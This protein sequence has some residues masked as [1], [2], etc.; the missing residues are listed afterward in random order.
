[1]MRCRFISLAVALLLGCSVAMADGL[2]SLERFIKGARSGRADF[3]QVVSAPS[4]AGE[5]GKTRTSSGSFAFSRPDRFRFDYRKPFAQTIVADGVT[6]WMYDADLNQV[7]SRKQADVLGST[8]AALIASASDLAVLRKDY[9]LKGEPDKDG[10]QW[11]L[12]TPKTKDGQ[13]QSVRVGFRAGDGVP[14]LVVLDILDSFGQRS[15][16]RFAQ[17]EANPALPA[18]LF[19]FKPPAGADVIRQ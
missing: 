16:L 12:A 18:D 1:M 4:R 8:P 19:Q 15:E 9:V 6:L 13:L 17:G 11:V 14:G 3:T 2:D 5:T 10:L 7:T